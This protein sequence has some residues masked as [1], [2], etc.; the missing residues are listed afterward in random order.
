MVVKNNN[1][2]HKITLRSHLDSVRSLAFIGNSL[3]TA[4]EDTT[5]K[6]WRKDE[7]SFTLR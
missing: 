6:I 3:I 7:L 4:G 2:N 5:V 1:W